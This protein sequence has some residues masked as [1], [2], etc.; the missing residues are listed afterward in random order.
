M[1]TASP[2]YEEE[3][4]TYLSPRLQG[5]GLMNLARAAL[6]GAYAYN[7]ETYEA[8]LELG[9][10][11]D[12]K[13][14]LTFAVKNMTDRALTYYVEATVTTDAVEYIEYGDGGSWF[15]TG[16]PQALENAPDKA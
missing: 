1:S 6:T 9:D 5:A 8:K 4:G 12:D 15:V 10:R 13:F 2:I 16:K 7:P 14:S 11:L 3:S